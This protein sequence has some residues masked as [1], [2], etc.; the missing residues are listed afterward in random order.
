MAILNSNL[1]C[2]FIRQI[3]ATR[4]GGYYEFKPMYISQIPVAALSDTGAIVMLV[5]K[6]LANQSVAPGADVSSLEQEIDHL[7]YR[8]YGLTGEDIAIIEDAG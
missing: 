5:E 4:Q 8:A 2:W 7:V 3:A 1:M 6:I